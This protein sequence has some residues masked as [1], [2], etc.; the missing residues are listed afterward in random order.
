MIQPEDLALGAHL[1]PD[2]RDIEAPTAD[3][4]EQAMDVE[5]THQEPSGWRSVEAPEWDA[6]EQAMV[7]PYDDD[8]R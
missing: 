3:A 6:Q 8:Y 2:E 7:V 5:P 1:D 4:A